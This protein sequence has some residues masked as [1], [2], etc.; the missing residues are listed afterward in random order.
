MRGPQ[1]DAGVKVSENLFG[2][3]RFNTNSGSQATTI[4]GKKS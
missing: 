1:D 4:M 3:H 2:Y